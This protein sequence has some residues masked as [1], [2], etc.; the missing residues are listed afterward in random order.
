MAGNKFFNK[1]KNEIKGASVF[2]S[3]LTIAAPWVPKT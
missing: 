3:N 1:I 2:P